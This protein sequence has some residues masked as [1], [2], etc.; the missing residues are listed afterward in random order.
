MSPIFTGWLKNSNKLDVTF[1]NND[2]CAKNAMP[3]AVKIV[4]TK[5]AISFCLRPQ[6]A[7]NKIV[8][9]KIEEVLAYDLIGTKI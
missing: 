8:A 2:H 7:A 3:K 1:D 4:P 9:V 5:T 6:I